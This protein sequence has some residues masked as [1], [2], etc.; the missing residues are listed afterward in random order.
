MKFSVIV[1]SYNSGHFLEETLRSIISQR[2]DGVQVEL[3]VVD[4]KSA[5]N[6][7]TLLGKF[8][9]DIDRLIVEEDTGPANAINKGLHLATGDTISWLNADDVYYPGTL[10]RVCSVLKGQ[11]EDVFCFGK[12]RIVD[13]EGSEIRTGITRFKE[14]FFP[15]SSRFTYQ[16]INYISQPAMFFRRSTFQSVGE[17]RE[18]MV[19]AWDYEFLLRLWKAGSAVIIPG[20]PVSAFRWHEQSIS[21]Q[22]F[23]IQFKEELDA[24]AQDAG[25]FS[26]QVC[27]HHIVRWGIIGAY[28]GM[29]HMRRFRNG[30]IVKNE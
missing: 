27:L 22:N 24:A 28:S 17:I 30:R 3:I 9:D 4:G 2:N 13:V 7:P 19:A 20:D 5:D 23:H 26:P 10:A 12:C 21:G 1:P 29:S 11:E 18:D 8:Q 25:K 15:V 6:T 14:C 16:C